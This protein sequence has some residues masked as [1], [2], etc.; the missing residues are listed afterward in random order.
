MA[1]V[2]SRGKESI[3]DFIFY[4]N[5]WSLL[6]TTA[7]LTEHI[8][9]QGTYPVLSTTYAG[10][11][12][13]GRAARGPFP[14]RA[15]LARGR[16]VRRRQLNTLRPRRFTDTEARCFPRRGAFTGKCREKASNSLLR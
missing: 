15:L 1:S 16:L 9:G 2:A 11:A 6:L 5:H 3:G 10:A 12:F 8:S 4:V 14:S 13:P 7:A